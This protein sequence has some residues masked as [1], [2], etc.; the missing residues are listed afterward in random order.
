MPSTSNEPLLTVKNLGLDIVPRRSR[1]AI[2]VLLDVDFTVARGE[3]VCVVGESGSGKSMTTRAIMRLLP[4]GA[5]PRGS[6]TFGGSD[7]FSM[8]AK[9]LSRFRSREIGMIYQDPRAHVNPLWTVGDFLTEGVVTSGLMSKPEARRKALALLQ[10]VGIP[11]GE[12]R[13]K[14][15]PHQLSGGLLQRMMIVMTLMPEPELIIA[16]EATTALDV[17]VQAD[18]MAVF[19]SLKKHRELSLLFITH[20]LDLAA[21]VADTIVVMY[22]GRVIE[23]GPARDVYFRPSHPYTS[24][25][26]RSRPNPRSQAKLESIPGRPIAAAEAGTGCAFAPRCPFAQARCRSSVPELREY[27]NGTVAC[28]R[29]EELQD[30]LMEVAG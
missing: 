18:V 22:A 19:A 16:D 14:Q 11:D 28:H 4:D 2:P 3:S 26:L 5:R 29:A 30:E 1:T 12:R 25:L 23:R 9:A 6:V 27:G 8:T 21:A 13:L 24:A 7:V 15:Y 17:T 20:D 10:E